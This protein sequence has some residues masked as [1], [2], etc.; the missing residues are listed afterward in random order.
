MNDN[1][2]PCKIKVDEG[3]FYIEIKCRFC[4]NLAKVKKYAEN[5]YKK[6]GGGTCKDCLKRISSET[7]KK[8]RAN[9][10][11]EERSE[12]GKYARSKS[13]ISLAVSNQWKNFRSN[14]EKY[15]EICE[16]KSKRMENVW[17]KYSEEK[18]NKIVS[19]LAS[20]K[21][22]GR[23]KLSEKFKQELIKNNLYDG[24][25][26]E[27]VF[28]GFIPDEINHSLKLVI[29]VQ[30]DLYHCN[31]LK[32]KNPNVFVKAIQRTVGEQWKRDEIKLASYYR[33]GYTPIVVWEH[34]IKKHLS[35]QIERIKQIIES[36]KP[37]KEKD[38]H[39][40]PPYLEPV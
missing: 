30:G 31:P 32:Y 36:H 33:N 12:A 20:S 10:T 1:R 28:H 23:S 2:T 3:N 37:L 29:E 27:E 8:L 4:D 16:A 14:P 5:Y 24:F 17:K 34:D 6:R 25:V 7:L 19:S 13:N 35:E 18:R 38:L 9:Q 11:P 22:C 26:S 21:N 40:V 39:G 15:K